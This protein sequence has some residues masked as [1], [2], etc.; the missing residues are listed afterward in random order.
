MACETA[1]IQWLGAEVQKL[2]LAP[3]DVLVVMVPGKLSNSQRSIICS[4]LS[5]QFPDHKALV[6]DDDIRIGTLSPSP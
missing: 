3:G 5:Q 6:L 4:Y 2:S 1:A